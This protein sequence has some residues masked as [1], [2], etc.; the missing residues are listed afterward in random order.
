MRVMHALVVGVVFAAAKF[1]VV[2]FDLTLYLYF[3]THI[4]MSHMR[5]V[6]ASC[7]G[8]CCV[9]CPSKWGPGSH[10]AIRPR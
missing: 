10:L 6:D 4:N 2:Y 8:G 9:G 3:Q 7:D 5:R 1:C